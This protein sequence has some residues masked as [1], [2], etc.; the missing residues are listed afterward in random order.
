MRDS[1]PT[2]T[3]ADTRPCQGRARSQDLAP[4]RLPQPHHPDHGPAPRGGSGAALRASPMEAP[5]KSVAFTRRPRRGRLAR[6]ARATTRPRQ[7]P[8]TPHSK[9]PDPGSGRGGG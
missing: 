2:T 5:G 7:S 8:T 4:L 3:A 9:V 6:G 1:N